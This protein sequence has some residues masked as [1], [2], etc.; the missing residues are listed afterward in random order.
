MV[1]LAKSGGLGDV[2]GTLPPALHQTGCNVA[3]FLP[4]YRCALTS[5]LAIK[6]TPIAFTIPMGSKF[7]ACR[8]LET[9]LPQ[10]RVPVY[11]IDQPQ[12]F[13]RP[14]LY[15]DAHGEYRDNCERFCFFSRAVAEA[16]DQ[17]GL[18][19]DII[20]SH[21]WQS[22]LLPAL[23]RARYKHFRWMETARSVMTI[24]NLAYQGQFWHL[25]MPLTGLGWEHFH[26][27]GMEFHGHL[28]LLKTG[29]VYADKITTVSPTYAREIMTP[30]QGCGLDSVL[31]QRQS[32]LCG[33][34]NGV[35][36]KQWDPRCDRHIPHQY[37]P[38]SWPEGKAACKLAL[39]QELGLAA[40]PGTPLV[41]IVSRLV[42]QKGWDLIIPL[43]ERWGGTREIQWAILGTGEQRYERKLR[44]LA[45]RH[46]PQIG[47]RLEFSEGLAHRIEAGADIFLMP[48]RFEPCGLN[49]LY[50]LK[51]GTVPVVNP[52]GGLADTVVDTTPQTIA[53]GT[54]T[55][56]HLTE[57]SLR[58]LE[59]AMERAV[60]VYQHHK[61]LWAQIV[62]RGMQEDWSWQRS[63][64]QYRQVYE[65]ALAL[66]G[67]S[68]LPSTE[69]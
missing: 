69:P 55:G 29:I 22:G 65:S 14:G 15:G 16:I 2:C 20:H 19:V 42:D 44:E 53:E 11:L 18:A 38:E 58:G 25:D 31:R 63:A 4:A 24:H 49:Q 46:A 33:I 6:P 64:R 41:G 9:E 51:Y 50:S 7:I 43:L 28:N 39:Q 67:R 8:L 37:G 5:G 61:P 27:Q 45:A 30:E 17:L 68:R 32:D 54:A 62:L 35:D 34:V 1:P 56:F 66:R 57:Y 59:Q 40:C 52:T 26:W 3:C 10:E 36:Y 21:D 60:E 48:S 13:D 47:A 12:Y 23:V